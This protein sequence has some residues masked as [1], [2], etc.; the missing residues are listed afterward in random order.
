VKTKVDLSRTAIVDR[1][2]DIAD[3]EGIAAITVRRL[4]QE[5]DVTPMALY[6]H[7]KNKDELLE[8][9]GDRF[10][11]DL[12]VPTG[13]P[14]AEQLRAATSALVTS[15]RRHP[16]AAHLAAP[17]V[18]QCNAGRDLAEETL[19]TLRKAGF[20]IEQATDIART[21]MQTAA[22]LVCEEAGAE[23]GVGA[24]KREAVR[25]AKHRAIANLPP[26]R[27]PNLV[28]C[29]TALTHTLDHDA[30]YSF[31]VD[32]FVSGVQ[33]LHSRRG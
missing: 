18:L 9:M 14:W 20:T 29:A 1:A 19:G 33:R 10:F 16:G 28:D 3:A 32:L 17:R 15:L 6:W 31:G 23:V 27:Y 13:G 12:D 11:D 2:L 22:M 30:Y 25:D 5:F 4:A 8:A 7:V 24:D 21:A 26:N